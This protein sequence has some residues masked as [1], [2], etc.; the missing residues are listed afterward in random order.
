VDGRLRK[1]RLAESSRTCEHAALAS[2]AQINID[3]KQS[4]TVCQSNSGLCQHPSSHSFYHHPSV[5]TS[6]KKHFRAYDTNTILNHSAGTHSAL[7][8]L[9]PESASTLEISRVTNL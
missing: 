9:A 6:T 3:D 7:L 8:D 4:L 1:T 5:L 2:D